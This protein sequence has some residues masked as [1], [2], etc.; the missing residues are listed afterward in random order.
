MRITCIGTVLTSG[1]LL[2]AGVMAPASASAATPGE[3]ATG[4]GTASILQ[5]CV[6]L[7]GV[8]LGCATYN[9]STNYL[10]ACDYSADGRGVSAELKAPDGSRYV[11]DGNGSA[12]GCGVKGMPGIINGKQVSLRVKVGSINGPWVYGLG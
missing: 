11:G 9:T 2:A 12:S 7:N 3:N 5:S 6:R 4:A 8:L 1:L 10:Y